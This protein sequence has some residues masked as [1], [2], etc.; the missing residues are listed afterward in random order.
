MS[1]TKPVGHYE[2][3]K[4]Q[5]NTFA[6]VK[7]L[8][9]ASHTAKTVHHH[10]TPLLPN[11]PSAKHMQLINANIRTTLKESEQHPVD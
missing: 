9:S 7:D 6:K 10:M 5:K 8:A 3:S 1:A 11:K 4:N 2:V